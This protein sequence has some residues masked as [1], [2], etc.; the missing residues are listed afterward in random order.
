MTQAL[1]YP[2]EEQEREWAVV[3][4]RLRRWQ[5]CSREIVDLVT[6]SM[7]VVLVLVLVEVPTMSRKYTPLQPKKK[8]P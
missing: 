6:I 2:L 7:L 1:R 3:G 8:E 5:P 4:R